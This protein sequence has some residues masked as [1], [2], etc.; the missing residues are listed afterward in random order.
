MLSFYEKNG[1][2]E[3]GRVRRMVR[4]PGQHQWKDSEAR[5]GSLTRRPWD[6]EW[7]IRMVQQGDTTSPDRVSCGLLLGP[8]RQVEQGRAARDAISANRLCDLN[9]VKLK[10]NSGRAVSVATK[11]SG[12]T[13][14]FQAPPPPGFGAEARR[15]EA[16]VAKRL[17]QRFVLGV[18]SGRMY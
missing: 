3:R 15:A 14:Q 1:T 17:A 6:S 16:V 18:R 11:F 12:Q 5:V 8:V 4:P 13:A 9:K 7:R 10:P 2:A